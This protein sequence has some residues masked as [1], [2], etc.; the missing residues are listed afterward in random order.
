MSWTGNSGESSSLASHLIMLLTVSEVTEMAKLKTKE[1]KRKVA[2][3]TVDEL[4]ELVRQVLREELKFLCSIDDEG[5]LVF[6][7]EEAYARYVELLGKKPSEVKAYWVEGGMKFR[8]SDDE[9]TPE[10]AKELDEAKQEPSVPEEKV[11]AELRKI[12]VSV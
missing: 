2:D 3:M 11:L 9:V 8:Y 5:N 12:G 1:E 6:G 7:C 4:A 10:L